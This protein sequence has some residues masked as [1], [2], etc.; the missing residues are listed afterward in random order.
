VDVRLPLGVRAVTVTTAGGD[1]LA[2]PLYDH[3]DFPEVRFGLLLVDRSLRL[4]HVTAYDQD[5]RQLDQFD[6][7]FHQHV[8]HD[9]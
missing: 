4:A 6:M 5:G 3:Q 7:S 9:E 2:M 1:V 8:W